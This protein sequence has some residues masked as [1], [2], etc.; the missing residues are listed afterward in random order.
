[1]CLIMLLGVYKD[2]VHK[3]NQLEREESDEDDAE[4]DLNG[5]KEL[6]GEHEEKDFNGEKL[7]KNKPTMKRKQIKVYIIYLCT[8]FDGNRS[9]YIHV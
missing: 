3:Q 4:K 8:I 7:D 6:N 1:M 2:C 5:E 9:R